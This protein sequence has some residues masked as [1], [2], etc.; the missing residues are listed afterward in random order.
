MPSS[1][2]LQ[3]GTI[4]F[5]ATSLHPPL[6]TS[7]SWAFEWPAVHFAERYWKEQKKLWLSSC[8][9]VGNDAGG[10][11]RV[12]WSCLL[13]CL[14]YLFPKCLQSF[15]ASIF[16]LVQ[17]RYKIL[18]IFPF[19]QSHWDKS[20]TTMQT[21][22]EQ[23]SAQTFVCSIEMIS[24]A[25]AHVPLFAR[26]CPS[27]LK[28]QF[29]LCISLTYVCVSKV[30][31]VVLGVFS[32]RLTDSWQHLKRGQ[33]AF[34]SSPHETKKRKT[35]LNSFPFSLLSLVISRCSRSIFFVCL[36]GGIC[37]TKVTWKRERAIRRGMKSPFQRDRDEKSRRKTPCFYCQQ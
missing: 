26:V 37:C 32:F 13:F 21:D 10:I 28:W 19:D 31:R 15:S 16:C 8:G 36:C 25:Y 1:V 18:L 17:V 20:D 30:D 3:L 11:D 4:S 33:F 27:V 6:K 14:C 5:C 9:V 24:L 22:V 12:M 34:V 35:R 2:S 29:H 23:K 7:A